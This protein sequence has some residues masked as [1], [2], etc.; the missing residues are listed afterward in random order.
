MIT[1]NQAKDNIA[2]NVKRLLA[3]RDWDQKRL[4]DETGESVMNISR[5]CRGENCARVGMMLRIAE[6]LD[7]SVNI[8]SQ[9]PP[10]EKLAPAS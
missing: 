2:A 1:D 6:A 4:A 3:A 5:V 10:A 8:L 9:K 7:T